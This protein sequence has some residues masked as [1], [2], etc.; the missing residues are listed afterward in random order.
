MVTRLELG[1]SNRPFKVDS[2]STFTWKI[3]QSDNY[4]KQFKQGTQ[5][6]EN[7]YYEQISSQKTS[8]A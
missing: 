2:Q 5:L 6:L 3:L 1:S 7:K 8:H 4:F